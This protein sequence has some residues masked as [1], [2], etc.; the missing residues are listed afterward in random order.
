M[1]EHNRKQELAADNF[2]N[3]SFLH[4]TKYKPLSTTKISLFTT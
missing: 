1:C 4:E 3:M 2:Y